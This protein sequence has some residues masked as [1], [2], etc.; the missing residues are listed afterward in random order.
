M[1]I[2]NQNKPNIMP[3]EKAQTKSL[4]PKAMDPRAQLQQASQMY[5]KHFLGE[6]VKAMR[7][8]VQKGGLVKDSM[9]D[10]IY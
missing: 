1:K 5:E 10:Q 2:S 9:A 8:S 4:R 6:M 7:N 3:M